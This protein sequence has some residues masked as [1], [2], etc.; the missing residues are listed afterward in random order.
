M[1]EVRPAADDEE[2]GFRDLL[3]DLRPG[4]QERVLALARH[5]AGHADDD[6]AV[7]EAVAL[8]DRAAS[9]RVGTEPRRVDPRVQSRHAG[10]GRRGQ[11][12]GD[13]DPEVLAQ[14]GDHVG[15]LADAAQQA[16]R[17]GQRRPAGLVPVGDRHGPFDADSA[18]RGRDQA[19]R[20]GGAE[21]DGFCLP[22]FGDGDGPA[23]DRRDRQHQRRWVPHDL[24]R[25]AFV[26]FFRAV[27][28]RG[29]DG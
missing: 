11:R 27:P 7:A 17:P 4:R 6:G 25:L 16:A 5:E 28:P 8:P 15:V 19:K 18:Q 1:S 26:E 12:A 24:E 22:S 13:P 23:G 14:V 3:Q 21:D 9:L 10:G 2:S 20:R 29:V